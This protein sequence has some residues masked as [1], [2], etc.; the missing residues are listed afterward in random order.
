[1]PSLGELVESLVKK[2]IL[3]TPVIREAMLK[4]DRANFVQEGFI[5]EA[6]LDEPL[7]AG[8]GQTISQPYTVAFMLELLLP[9]PGEKFLD[10]GYG[11]GWQ[12]AILAEIVGEKGKIYAFEILSALCEFGKNNIAKYPHLAGRIDFF[13]RS[14]SHGLEKEAERIG[15]FDGIIAAAELKEVPGDWRKQI[16]KGG[17]LVYPQKGGIVKEIK[18]ADNKFVTQRHEGFKF[19]PYIH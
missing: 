13:C 4:I 12:S 17:R 2:K 16:K 6:Y 9:K 18:L 15:G 8:E 19:V 5:S 3:R 10:V 11:S 1:M 7:L 14:A